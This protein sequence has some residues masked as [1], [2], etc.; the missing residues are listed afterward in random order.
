MSDAFLLLGGCIL[1]QER[2][3][4]ARRA[5]TRGDRWSERYVE[6]Q[7]VN[8]LPTPFWVSGFERESEGDGLGFRVWGLGF[9][10]SSTLDR[11]WCTAC[12]KHFGSRV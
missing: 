5:G 8:R 2:P 12:Q 1:S 10:C 6:A 7:L 3:G 4:P 9:V 11:S